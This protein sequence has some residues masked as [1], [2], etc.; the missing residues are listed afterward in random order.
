MT[1]PASSTT[2]HPSFAR[3]H[4]RKLAALALW[5]GMVLVYQLYAWR[6]GLTPLE[7]TRHLAD[8][9]SSGAAGGLIF[10]AVYASS[11]LVLFPPTLLTVASGFVFGPVE[12][13]LFAALGANAAGCV[14]YLMGRHL[15]RESP[16]PENK[17]GVVGRYAGWMKENGFQSVLLMRLAYTPFDP[18]GLLAGFLRIDWKRFVL[19]TMLGSLPCTVS[20]VLLGASFQSGLTNAAFGPDP[21][22]LLASAILFAGSLIVSRHLKRR[23]AQSKEI[24]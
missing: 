11:T 17:P 21:R 22:A 2:A 14:S 20:F 5:G 1:E 12:G 3:R 8:L 6:D 18:V 19:A 9:A 24:R 4:G 23:A 13:V 16:G 10:V 15:G 7:A